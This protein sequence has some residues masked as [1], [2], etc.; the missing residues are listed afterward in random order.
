MRE[1]HSV[2]RINGSQIAVSAVLEMIK[3]GGCYPIRGSGH[4]MRP[5][6][7][8]NDIL[9]VTAL[10]GKKIRVGDIL[11]YERDNGKFVFHRVYKIHRDGTYSFVGDNQYRAENGIRHDQLRAYVTRV[12]R[13]DR[14]IDC[15]KLS[16]RIPMVIYMWYRVKIPF[17]S[18]RIRLLREKFKNASAASHNRM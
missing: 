13:K 4:S 8:E 3:D 9:M 11:L 18:Y 10:K 7:D 17:I 12:I 14:E 1:V 16:I 2:D 6:L 15:E 5:F